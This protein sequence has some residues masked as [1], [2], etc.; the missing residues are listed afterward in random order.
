MVRRNNKSEN[1]DLFLI[2]FE[3]KKKEIDKT[4]VPNIRICYRTETLQEELK[5]CQIKI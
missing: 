5:L 4:N 1:F 3:K 2:I